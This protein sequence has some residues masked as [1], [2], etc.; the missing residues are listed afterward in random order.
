MGRKRRMSDSRFQQIERMLDEI[1]EGC[2]KLR[3]AEQYQELIKKDLSRLEGEKHAYF[4]RKNELIGTIADT[5]GMAVIAP[6]HKLIQMKSD[7]FIAE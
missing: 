2:S 5:K 3:E 4:Y 1:E 6:R 7:D